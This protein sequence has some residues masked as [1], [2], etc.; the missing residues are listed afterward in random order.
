MNRRS[1]PQLVLFVA[2]ALPLVACTGTNTNVKKKPTRQPTVQRTAEGAYQEALSM[3][4]QMQG[5]GKAD[6]TQVIKLYR[7]AIQLNPSMANAHFNLAAI[8]EK[9]GRYKRAAQ[10]LQQV[11]QAEPNNS[12]AMYRLAQVYVRGNQPMRAL[13]LLQRF[14]RKN[15][16]AKNSPRMLLNLASVQV[17]NNSY[18]QALITA[19]KCLALDSKN[20]AAYRLIARVYLRQ[21]RYEGVHVV[22]ALSQKL[23][24]KD[25]RLFNI[26]GRAYMEQK[27]Y[28]EAIYSFRQAV[29]IEPT[30]FAAQMNL[31]TLALQYYDKGRA[32]RALS[33][34]T[35]LRPQDRSALLAYAVAL[36]ANKKFKD[37]ES[38][39]VNRL[40]KIQSNDSDSIFNLGVLYLRF[41][42]KPKKAK[43]MFRRYIGIKGATIDQSHI[44]YK[45]MNQ[46]EQKIKA[47]EMMKKMQEQQNKQDA[48]KKQPPKKR[49]DIPKVRVP[50]DAAGAPGAPGTPPA[51]GGTPNSKTSPPP[52]VRK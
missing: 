23:G 13:P 42:N 14:I 45:L 12:D 15:P 18:G 9:N 31:G 35:R 3:H 50:A 49:I 20:I 48:K 21:K 7:E 25:A 24:K 26:V 28:P 1:I 46:A 51:K 19:R 41:L 43:S 22:Y 38:V 27:K 8:Y 5:S 36:R 17:Q 29:A 52:P 33:Q 47:A 34:A 30:L 32:L 10:H 11:L 16:A 6:Y 2:A 4:Q 44:S 37:A 39:Y 40:L